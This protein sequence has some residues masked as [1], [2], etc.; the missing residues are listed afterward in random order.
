MPWCFM[1]LVKM[2]TDTKYSDIIE[3]EETPIG[4]RDVRNTPKPKKDNLDAQLWRNEAHAGKTAE[5]SHA[6][7]EQNQAEHK[8]MAWSTHAFL[9]RQLSTKELNY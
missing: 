6:S 9:I 7:K 4:T 1:N 8:K 5:E 2:L 3:G